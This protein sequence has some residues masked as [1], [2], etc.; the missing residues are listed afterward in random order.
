[1]ISIDPETGNPVF[2]EFEL[3]DDLAALLRQIDIPS[4]TLTPGH[5]DLIS[6]IDSGVR[7]DVCRHFARHL[8]LE[9][10]E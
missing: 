2:D 6:M 10:S 5:A 3:P 8:G 1:M 4:K 7:A 9:V